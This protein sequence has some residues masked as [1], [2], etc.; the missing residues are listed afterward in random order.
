MKMYL[1]MDHLRYRINFWLVANKI[2]HFWHEGGDKDS[3]I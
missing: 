1:I 3:I 2:I